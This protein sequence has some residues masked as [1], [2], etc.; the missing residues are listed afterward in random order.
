MIQDVKELC[1]E[2][3]AQS[4]GQVCRLRGGEVQFGAARSNERVA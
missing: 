1:S 2:L 3:Q 4:F